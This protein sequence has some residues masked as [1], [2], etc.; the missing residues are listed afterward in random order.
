M[1]HFLFHRPTGFFRKILKKRPHKEAQ[2]PEDG[3]LSMASFLDQ[4][5]GSYCEDNMVIHLDQCI[6]PSF[7]LLFFFIATSPSRSH[8]SKTYAGRLGR[9]PSIMIS[10]STT[11]ASDQWNASLNRVITN[12]N[13]L[14]NLDEFLGNQV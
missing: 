12:T 1:V 2:T 10:H 5:E 7:I 13:E 3:D 14:R 11:R 6:L 4:R 9:T 8:N